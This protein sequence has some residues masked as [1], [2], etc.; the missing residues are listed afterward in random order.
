[1]LLLSCKSLSSQK[2]QLFSNSVKVLV[3]WWWH[4]DFFQTF[5]GGLEN[6]VNL[7]KTLSFCPSLLAF[8]YFFSWS[9]RMK[10]ETSRFFTT[11]TFTFD[12]WVWLV[13]ICDYFN[14]S[15]NRMR[16]HLFVVSPWISWWKYNL[17]SQQWT[18]DV[19]SL[20]LDFKHHPHNC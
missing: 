19:W 7:Y 9:E 6:L 13:L 11:S 10:E 4:T 2:G 5:S 18:A 3:W 20:G 16:I 12:I 1:M 14:T 15:N 17:D 8:L